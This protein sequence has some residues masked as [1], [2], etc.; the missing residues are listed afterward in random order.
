MKTTT[1]ENRLTARQ[2]AE[3]RQ[4][5]KELDQEAHEPGG[6]VTRCDPEIWSDFDPSRPTGRQ[7]YESYSDAELLDILIRTMQRPGHSPRFEEVY[8]IYKKYLHKRFEGLHNA[9]DRAK[10]RMKLLQNQEKWP[11]DWP[12]HV[13]T[14]PLLEKLR[15]RGKNISKEDLVLLT[16]LC[17]EARRTGL[18]P[19]ITPSVR[20]RLERL[21]GCTQT[22]ELMGIPHLNKTALKHMQRYWCAVRKQAARSSAAKTGK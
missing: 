3:Y 7:I 16:R 6:D 15:E 4:W 8:C 5:L 14:E 22:L 13:S 21:Y 19:V 18:P 10:T 17:E 1:T 2:I 9:K 12:E 20:Q 11:P